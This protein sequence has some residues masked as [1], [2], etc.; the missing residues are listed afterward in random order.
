MNEKQIAKVLVQKLLDMGF[1]VHRYNAVTTN[2]I[3][4]KLDYGVCCGIRLLIIME[5]RNIIID[6]ML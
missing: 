2:S 1:T 5:K 3:Y 6:L 4:L